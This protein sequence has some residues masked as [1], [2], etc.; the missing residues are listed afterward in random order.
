MG[1]KPRER[2]ESNHEKE[3][4]RNNKLKAKP[5]TLEEHSNKVTK[6]AEHMTIDQ[7]YVIHV[8]TETNKTLNKLVQPVSRTHETE[9]SAWQKRMHMSRHQNKGIESFMHTCLD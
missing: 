1:T 5:K 9:L 2:V 4:E 3:K 7:L 6:L 8:K